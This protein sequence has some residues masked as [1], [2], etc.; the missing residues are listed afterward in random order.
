MRRQSFAVRV[1]LLIVSIVASSVL[2]QAQYGA[3]IQG[4]VSDKSGAIVK[5]AKVTVTNQ[6]TGVAQAV[7][8]TQSGFYHVP[9]LLPG[10]Y[11]VDV[12]SGGFRKSHN[13]NVQV[14]AETVRGLD[15]ALQPGGVQ[16]TVTVTSEGSGVQ[17][18]TASISGGISAKQIEELPQFGRD[19]FE[20]LRLAPGIFGDGAR[21]GSGQAQLLPNGAGPGGSNNSL[22][23]VENQTQVSA[24]GQ[25]V[26]G[27]N[28]LI[29]GV[30]VNSLTWGGASVVTPNQE[31]V[32]E[33][34]VISTSYSA[35]DGRNS[36]AQVKVVSKSGS[37]AFHGSG[38]F[39]YGEPG[40]N[41]F[42]TF[43]GFINGFERAPT[44]RVSN[45]G[46]NYGGSVGGPIVKGKLFFSPQ[47]G[48]TII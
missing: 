35:E 24:N 7:E 28:F 36:G 20:L 15:V 44:T 22:Y 34:A 31:S 45:K 32:A 21:N 41:A 37:N 13:A 33:V 39:K 27:N 10:Q 29:D 19:P 30:D 6:S 43:N 16:E 1:A 14:D 5:G 26:S 25:R 18:E 42:N 23:Q 40:L 4:T 38:F 3:S 48:N 17:S 46:R 12:E 11:T 2:V 8:T 47:R 9:A